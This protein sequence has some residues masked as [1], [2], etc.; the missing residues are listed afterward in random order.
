MD[1]DYETVTGYYDTEITVKGSRFIGIVM[2]CPEEEDIRG[3]LEH[4]TAR[5][6]GATHYCYAAVFHGS[7]RRERF[8]DNGEPSGTAGRPIL[9]A[10]RG[11]GL[12]DVICIV[13][14]YFGG[15]LLGTG[16]LVHTYTETSTLALSGCPRSRRTYCSCY[17]LTLGYDLFN[18]FLPKFRGMLVGEPECD[19][20]ERVTMRLY[21]R[22]PDSESFLS[23]ITE[24][25]EGRIAPSYLG[26]SYSE[27]KF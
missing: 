1:G 14:R 4:V 20:A 7:D 5:Y 12:S 23:R 6:P 25:T 11:S 24:F 21:V 22:D 16:G 15:T 3:C 13:V 10:V 9:S 17:S 26:H 2:R 18:S 27:T 8:S 19:Y